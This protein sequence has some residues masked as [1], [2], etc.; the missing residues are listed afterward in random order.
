MALKWPSFFQQAQGVVAGAT[1][2]IQ[3]PFNVTGSRHRRL[4][5][6]RHNEGGINGG[7]LPGFQ[8]GK[9]FDVIVK[10]FAD[11][12]DGGFVLVGLGHNGARSMNEWLLIISRQAVY[13]KIFQ[14]V[15]LPLPMAGQIQ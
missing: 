10:A 12:R 15:F 13:G 14:G 4:G 7:G 5:Q 2:D 3:H 11:F 8:V 6:Q 9:T 1:T